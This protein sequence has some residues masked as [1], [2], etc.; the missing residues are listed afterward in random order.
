[1][2]ITLRQLQI[3]TAIAEQGSTTAA[4]AS[5]PLSQSAT[6]AALGELESLL[7]ASLFDRI[8]KRLLLNET[9][10]AL[11]S[12]ARALLDA[13]LE[14]EHSFGVGTGNA[15]PVPSRIRL[16][17]STT[18]GNY[19]MPAKIAR[20]LN[21]H[22]HACVEMRIGNTQEIVGAVQRME[23]DAGVIEGPCHA[24]ELEA[25]PWQ[26]DE[27]VIVTA[28][29]HELASRPQPCQLEELRKQRWLLR[30]S[31]SGTREAVDNALLPHLGGFEQTLVLGSTEAIKQAAAAG[32]GIACLPRSAVQDLL[33][34]GRL[35][36][37][38]T[39]LP[40]LERQLYRIRHRNKRFSPA[41]MQL[42]QQA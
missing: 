3:F 23:V 4:A 17:A 32:L 7:G 31:G 29:S 25:L 40:P 19:L 37:L 34:L 9:G 22:P 38:R 1:M 30:E 36:L 13:A 5:M 21:D 18:I 11:L 24:D 8:G 39:P 6:S 26:A 16:G 28:A 33:E 2:R 27:L 12:P 42:L 10:R 15:G 35:L 14:I 20:L 41:L